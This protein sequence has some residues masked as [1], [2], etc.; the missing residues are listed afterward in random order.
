MQ[1]PN[2]NS[3][4]LQ[5]SHP[6][7]SEKSATWT[8]NSKSWGTSLSLS[9]YLERELY[10]AT[11][12]E[13]T[14]DGGITHW[15]L[16]DQYSTPDSRPILA[17]VETVRKRALISRNGQVKEIITHA[18]GSVFCN[19]EYRGRGYAGRMLRELGPILN[20]WQTDRKIHGRE[21]CVFSILY[22]DIGKKYY[23]K[24]GWLPFPSTHISF[25]PAMPTTTKIATTSGHNNDT[26]IATVLK[27]A[28]IEV[29]CALD[30]QNIRKKL[31]QARDGRARIA[32]V[33]DYSQMK[34]HYLREDFMTS[35][36]FSKSP[37]NRGAIA[38]TP[39]NRIWAIWTRS[40][41][42]PIEKLESG[43]TLHFLRLV[44][45]DENDTRG[46]LDKL[47][48][49]VKIAQKEAAEWKCV[50]V[51]I[52]N[53]SPVVKD[54]VTELNLGHSEIDRDEESIPSLMWYGEGTGDDV[55]WVG[56]EKFGWF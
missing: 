6:T 18:I 7:E 15:I 31:A 48:G 19:P 38:G 16:V 26:H 27:D 13:L 44:I 36:I 43:N 12:P 11:V 25:T 5:L 3:A 49:I 45:E 20:K 10:T 8:L 33:P 9:D 17:S 29:L 54:I 41:Y 24:H 37:S 22:S 52:W 35:R 53:P 4:T 40:F 1:L 30:E 32:L 55:V 47:R 51:E 56:N 21:E 2:A 42:G 50:G 34:W 39:G 14:R 46:N 28:D 23:A